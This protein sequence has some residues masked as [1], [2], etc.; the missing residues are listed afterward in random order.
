MKIID[1]HC[2]TIGEIRQQEKLGKSLCLRRNHLCVDLEKMKRGDYL[3]QTF[4]IFI[5]W[6]AEPDAWAAACETLKTFKREMAENEDLISLVS[7]YKELEENEQKGRMSALLSLEE[8]A[9]YQDS[10]ER[11][12]WFH[13]Q[14]V[15]MATL[16]WNY[17]NKLA[18]P[19]FMGNPLEEK[20][21]SRGDDRGLKNAGLEFLE[22]M[23]EL[24]IIPDV[25][26]LSDGGFR[27]VAKYAKRPFVA[28]HSN[29]RG[30]VPGAAR[31]LTDDMIR[32]LAEKGGV[33]GLNYAVSFM[34][35]DWKPNQTG[36]TMDEI[37]E[38]A[39]YV[40]NTGGMECL[41]LGSDFDGILEA[42]EMK[43]CGNMQRL[44]DRFRMKGFTEGQ[45]EKIFSGNVK[46]FL[47]E[48]L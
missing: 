24:H 44:A 45:T 4:A 21:W 5:D 2:D 46:R 43:D 36:T 37:V 23:E 29:A 15:R 26:H 22:V 27:D 25:S 40:V 33:M 8:G 18:Y 32:M 13:E 31:N 47:K 34:R 6:K 16:T 41:G 14:G 1:M 20:I 17:E 39:K 10:V 28:S 11:L 35:P 48:N 38:M 3:L 30:R 42:P 19:N 9:I 7:S 12:R